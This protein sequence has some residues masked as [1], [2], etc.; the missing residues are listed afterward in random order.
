MAVLLVAVV[1]VGAQFK[2]AV[3]SWYSA[4][5]IERTTAFPATDQPDQICLTWSGDPR[6]TQ[7]VQWRTSTAIEDGC[8]QYR[9]K[10]QDGAE[11]AQVDA[12]PSV[13]ETPLVKND[14][15]NHRFSAVL[16]DLDPATAYTYRVGSRQKD[17]WSGW[18]DF[19]TAPEGAPAFSFVYLGDP[20]V[21]LESWGK[22][23]HT[24]QERH[25]STAFY[26]VAGDLVDNGTQRNM[27]DEFFE[28]GRGVFDH[29]PIV[30]ALGN[31]DYSIRRE[32]RLYLNLF[33]L[34]EVGGPKGFTPEH[35]YSFRYGNALFI[36]LD[37]NLSPKEQA[38]WL[39]D[40]LAHTDATWKFALFH[41]PLYSAKAHRD[42]K[43]IRETWGPIF[44]QYHLDMALQGHDH[45]YL[46]TYP[47]REQHRVD[48][49]KEG[50][51]YVV[52]V[53][54]TKYY[55]LD[56]HDY[57]AVSFPDTQTYQVIDIATNPDRLTYRAYDSQNNV[58][59]ELT[60]EK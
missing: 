52:S 39:E 13:L 42:D 43:E 49:P 30:P 12:T 51:I 17:V 31:H 2:G 37:S 24:A 10:G 38:P 27:W 47:M 8:V 33:T 22:L 59:D 46:R 53:S 29:S 9:P 11:A 15:V 45:A 19:I 36:I 41:H 6:T 35:D 60:I 20:Q 32:P 3:I 14:P 5:Y 44:D 55:K 21:G 4:N 58:K 28:A 1:I 54:G 23:L 34:P 48:T 26:A 56:K 18:A 57:A 40:L 25:P 7:A 16:Q 50:T